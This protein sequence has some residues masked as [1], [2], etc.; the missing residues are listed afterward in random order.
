MSTTMGL[1]DIMGTMWVLKYPLVVYIN[2]WIFKNYNN[3]PS[4]CKYYRSDI[5]TVLYLYKPVFK[6]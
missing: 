5:K 6:N 2:P 1:D 3:A 4:N